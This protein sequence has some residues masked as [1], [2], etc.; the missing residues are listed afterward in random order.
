MK[1]KREDTGAE[2]VKP[3]NARAEANP[4]DV[5]PGDEAKPTPAGEVKT[6]EEWA[7]AKKMDQRFL[8][9]TSVIPVPNPDFQDYAQARAHAG[10]PIGKELTE[11]QFDAAVIAAKTPTFG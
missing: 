1:T 7:V 3:E 2:D 9:T 11:A 4:G 10:W 5:K 8:P 6:A